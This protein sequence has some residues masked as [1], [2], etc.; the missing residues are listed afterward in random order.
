ML[1]IIAADQAKTLKKEVFKK[2]DRLWK[3]EQKR[4]RGGQLQMNGHLG[5]CELEAGRLSLS[6]TH[7]T[8]KQPTNNNCLGG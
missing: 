2:F 3:R 5:E 4:E 6:R 1:A 8:T 7:Q